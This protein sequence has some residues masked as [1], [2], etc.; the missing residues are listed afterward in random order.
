MCTK[1]HPIFYECAAGVSKAS[2]EPGE[3]GASCSFSIA[4][5]N[6]ISGQKWPRKEGNF[7]LSICLPVHLPT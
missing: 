6:V 3:T 7:H 5:D 1:S 2:L 4:Q